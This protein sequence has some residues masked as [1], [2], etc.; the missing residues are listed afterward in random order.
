M[1]GQTVGVGQV[2]EIRYTTTDDGAHVAYQVV[3]DGPL[4]IVY[5]N[6][7]MSHIE[8]SWE[9]PRAVAFYERMASF[10]RLILFDRRG[11]GLSD[12]IVGSF[13]IED[14][15]ADLRAVIDALDLERPVLLGSSEGGMTCTHF[16][17]L[18]PDR[19]SA[20]ILFST[21]VKVV[22]SDDCPW[23]WS[24]EFFDL[25]L[26]SVDQSWSDPTGASVAVIN[27][28]LQDDAD[29]LAWYAKYFRLSASPSLARALIEH[30]V[31]I[32]VRDLLPLVKVPTLVL[33]RTDETWLRIE[34]SRYIAHA[35]PQA[36][37]VELPGT[38]HYI[39]EEDATSVVDEIE[40]FLTGVRSER[41]AVRSLK[42]MVFTDIVGST[43]QANR[44]GDERWMQALGRHDQM[45]R[46]QTERFGGT[47]VK[48]IGDGSLATFDSPARAIRA[49]LAMHEAAR[50]LDLTLR[51]GIHTG[52]VEVRDDDVGGIAVHI[53]SRVQDRAEP[54]EVLV[55]RTVADLV[56]GSGTD[57]RDRGTH[58]LKG[59]PGAWQ[60][61]AVEA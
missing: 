26:D 41:Q 35:I 21:T 15:S 8:F 10:G 30:T 37:L 14:R 5:A 54:G 42:T 31:D 36:T 49:A 55:S 23:G 9:Y 40:E 45:L 12:P 22:A 59:V 11:T 3:G 20:L 53:A 7:F 19:V 24:R 52:E 27:P 6:S 16:A 43:E 29:A 61:F 33:H 38:D 60:L 2:P 18:E 47:F 56:A 46:R 4:D 51:I 25:F 44:R 57:L 34:G 39:W 17:A 48:S 50:G 28:S 58:E 32:D 1:Q 13:D